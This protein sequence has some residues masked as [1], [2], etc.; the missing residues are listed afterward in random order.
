VC[1]VVVPPLW[2]MAIIICLMVIFKWPHFLSVCC[3][4]KPQV[5]IDSL[6]AS[7]FHNSNAKKFILQNATALP[8]FQCWASSRRHIFGYDRKQTSFF[9]KIEKNNNNLY[10]LSL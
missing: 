1:T 10:W 2:G 9:S 5:N 8:M 7:D 3:R 4:A 6:T